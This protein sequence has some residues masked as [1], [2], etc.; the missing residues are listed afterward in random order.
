MTRV[1]V[2]IPV[3]P[4]EHHARWIDECIA[5]VQYQ[6]RAADD[7]V[8]V[9]DM[10]GRLLDEYVSPYIAPYNPGTIWKAPWRLG[11]ATAFNIGCALAFE[12]G[13]DLALMLGADD[14]LEPRV[15]ERL[16][17]TYEREGGRDGYYWHGVL[18]QDGTEQGLPCNDAAVTPGFMRATGGL[19]VEASLG[20]MDAALVSILLVHHPDWLIR[21]AGSESRFWSRQHAGQEGARL[22]S[23][24]QDAI[25]AVRHV[26]TRDFRAPTWGRFS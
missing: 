16:V 22:A 3:G 13:S 10:H 21:V 20:G 6:T 23:F 24:G 7:I 17:E 14:R 4:E 2:V 8:I 12:R 15:I 1:A 18:Y 26:L 9:D 11:V 5:S 25:I 19:P